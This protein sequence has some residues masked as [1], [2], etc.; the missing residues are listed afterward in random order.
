MRVGVHGVGLVPAPDTDSCALDDP[1]AVAAVTRPDL[2]TV[3]EV[4]LAVQ[5]D[6][7]A[8]GVMVADHRTTAA[9]PA[10]ARIAVDVDPAG[11]AD[12]FSRC[13]RRL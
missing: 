3:A 6:R 12:Q 13:L 9:R 5:R 11:F 2:L 8:R 4:N 1:L 10:N 7:I